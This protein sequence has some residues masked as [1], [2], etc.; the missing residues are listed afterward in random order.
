MRYL[1]M[2]YTL[3]GDMFL[4]NSHLLVPVEGGGQASCPLFISSLP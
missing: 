4:S 3:N 2:S 1:K